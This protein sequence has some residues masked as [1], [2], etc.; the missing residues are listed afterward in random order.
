MFLTV[1]GTIGLIIGTYSQNPILAFFLGLISHY[2]CDIIP[3]G[4]TRAPK[5]YNN[6][7]YWA[8]AGIIDIGILCL[9]LLSL[10]LFHK[11]NIFNPNLSAAF[12]GSVLPD[13]LLLGYFISNKKVFKLPFKLH[14]YLHGLISK[15]Y[16][17]PFWLGLTFQ[18]FLFIISLLIYIR[19]C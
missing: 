3:H 9:V 5:K 17:W 18:I 13:F 1:H 8:L 2:C 12:L 15:Y 10:Y 7:I 11:I 4:D 19:I 14:Y 16:E 6:L